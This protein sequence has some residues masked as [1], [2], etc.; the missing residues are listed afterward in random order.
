MAA[1]TDG[2]E[3]LLAY[4]DFRIQTAIG[5]TLAL[6]VLSVPTLLTWFSDNPRAG[7]APASGL[8]DHWN[9]WA[10]L[11]RSQGGGSARVGG[12]PAGFQ[13]GNLESELAFPVVVGLVVTLLAVLVTA[14][15][16]HLGV[17]LTAAIAGVVTFA[18]EMVLRFAGNGD[19]HGNPGPHSY[20]TGVGLALAQWTTAAVVVWALYVMT[21][22]R[23]DWRR[24]PADR[25]AAA[26]AS[27][28]R[29]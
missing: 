9:L 4:I 22:A 17:A 28:R 23:R 15:R 14:A 13:I 25:L 19:H 12:L 21:A 6:I 1:S 29:G 24:L 7:S 10:V 2:H 27:A 3:G 20:N 26:L 5:G 8:V 18:L 16:A 11:S